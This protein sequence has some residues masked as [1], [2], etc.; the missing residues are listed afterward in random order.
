L[1]TTAGFERDVVDELKMGVEHSSR[2]LFTA[3]L[4]RPAGFGSGAMLKTRQHTLDLQTQAPSG[5][6]GYLRR[7][8]GGMN[9]YW[10]G[11]LGLAAQAGALLPQQGGPALIALAAN[12]L[13][14][15]NGKSR[16]GITMDIHGY[17]S[18][19]SWWDPGDY[20]MDIHGLSMDIH[21]YPWIS[22]D[23]QGYRVLTPPQRRC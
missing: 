3:A 4:G 23:I 9:L 12:N 15:P 2:A 11:L 18:G 5:S 19:C 14:N 21:G 20:M 1:T 7:I 8:S 17:Q 13:R 16:E 6:S 22:M 10:E